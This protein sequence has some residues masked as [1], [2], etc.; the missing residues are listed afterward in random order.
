LALTLPELAKRKLGALVE[1]RWSLSVE[2]LG[3][4][5]LSNVHVSVV[6][7]PQIELIRDTAELRLPQR[8][9]EFGADPMGMLIP[10]IAARSDPFESATYGIEK[11]PSVRKHPEGWELRQ[12]LGSLHAFESEATDGLSLVG[13]SGMG[14]I[15]VAGPP[16]ESVDGHIDIRVSATAENRRGV[17][18]KTIPMQVMDDEFFTPMSLFGP[19]ALSN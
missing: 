14:Y 19:P 5:T 18:E 1:D 12:S 8:P 13:V 15:G 16:S 10:L 3:A 4:T 7:P 2:N 11:G 6:L 9:K 17:I